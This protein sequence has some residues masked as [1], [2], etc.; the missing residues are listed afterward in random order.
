MS[1]RTLRRFFTSVLPAFA[2]DTLLSVLLVSFITFPYPMMALAEEINAD[3]PLLVED[4]PPPADEPI[5]EVTDEAIPPEEIPVEDVPVDDGTLIDET[6]T[7][8]GTPTDGGDVP[9]AVDPVIDDTPTLPDFSPEQMELLADGKLFASDPSLKNTTTTGL[10]FSFKVADAI[11]DDKTDGAPLAT[12][13]ISKKLFELTTTAGELADFAQTSAGQDILDGDTIIEEDAPTDD[14]PP[15]DEETP[16]DEVPPVDEEA[17]V[18]EETPADEVPPVEEESPIDE[19]PP[20][21]EETPTDEVPPV[22]EETP[23]DT[24]TPLDTETP[25]DETPTDEESPADDT[26]VLDTPVDPVVD[27]DAPLLDDTDTETIVDAVVEATPNNLD[28]GIIMNG[29]DVSSS[30]DVSFTVGSIVANIIPLENAAP[31]AYTFQLVYANPVNGELHTYNQSF[32]LGGIAFNTDKDVYSVG[33]AGT[34]D[35]GV[36]DPAGMPFCFEDGSAYPTL[37]ITTPSGDEETVSVVNTGGCEILDSRRTDPDYVAHYQ[38]TEEG[39]YTMQ[40][41]VDTGAGEVALTRKITVGADTMFTVEREA[42]TRLFPDGESPMKIKITAHED[43][44]GNIMETVPASFEIGKIKVV[45]E[46]QGTVGDTEVIYSGNGVQQIFVHDLNLVAG[47]VLHFGY[48][49]DA[50]DVSP[51]FFVISPLQFIGTYVGTIYEGRAW[52]IVN[53]NPVEVSDAN[54]V[55]W[56][57]ADKDTYTDV[58][59][60]VPATDGTLVYTWKDSAVNAAHVTQSTSGSRPTYRASTA[61][62]AINFHPTLDFDGG[63]VLNNSGSLFPT[64]TNAGTVFLVGKHDSVSSS[65]D[66]ALEISNDVAIFGTLNERPTMYSNTSSQNPTY[67]YPTITANTAMMQTIDW[68]GGTDSTVNLRSNGGLNTVSTTM[69]ITNMAAT[70]INVGGNGDNWLGSLSEL[71]VYKAVLSQSD[72]E[73]IESYLAVKYGITLEQSVTTFAS[74][75]YSTTTTNQTSAGSIGQTFVATANGTVNSISFHVGTSNTAPTATVYLCDA[76]VSELA[77]T[78]IAGNPGVGKTNKVV[79]LPVSPAT[80]TTVT[81]QFD[82]G[83]SV[84]SG[85]EYVFHVK[86]TSGTLYLNVMTAN[87]RYSAGNQYT[88]DTSNTTQD[89]DFV[90]SGYRSGGRD[91][92]ASDGNVVFDASESIDISANTSSAIDAN[93]AST[94]SDD[95]VYN[96]S[97]VAKDNVPLLTNTK[98][99]SASETIPFLTTEIEDAGLLNDKEFMFV[100]STNAAASSIVTTDMPV[101]GIPA[102]TNSRTA[103]EW[104][105]QKNSVVGGSV[106]VDPSMGTFELSFDL[107]AMGISP[108][109][110]SGY[111]LVVDDNGDFTGGTQTVYPA[112]GEPSYDSATNSV[113]FTGVS[114]SDGQYFTL[115]IP[116][117]APGGVT[118]GL[119]AWYKADSGAYADSISTIPAVD[120][121]AVAVWKDQSGNGYNLS[122]QT[123]GP[124]YRVGTSTTAINYSPSVDFEAG[125]ND[126]LATA[127]PGVFGTSGTVV[128]NIESYSVLN[129][130]NM[131]SL[132]NGSSHFGLWGGQ[133]PN[134]IPSL[135]GTTLYHDGGP[136]TVSNLHTTTG[137]VTNQPML[138][139]TQSYSTGT[140]TQAIMQ[141]GKVVAMNAAYTGFTTTNAATNVGSYTTNIQNI[142]GALGDLVFYNTQHTAAEIARINSYLAFKY[143]ITMVGGEH[144]ITHNANITTGNSVG[145][146]FTAKTTASITQF[147]FRTDAATINSASG[148]LYICTGAVVTNPNS[149]NVANCVASPAYQQAISI[150]TTVSTDFTVLLSTAFP[151]VAGTS[152]A[153]IVNGTNIRLRG[154]SADIYPGAGNF[155]F[156]TAGSLSPNDLYFQYTTAA[157][158]YIASNGST[159]IWDKDRAGASTHNLGIAGVGR[160]D[161][162]GL[163]KYKSKSQSVLGSPIVEVTTQN[164]ATVADLEFLTIGGDSGALGAQ[165]T[166]L[167]AGLPA[168]TNQRLIRE[169]QV[170]KVGDVGAVNLSWDLSE[171][172]L[173]AT[174]MS[175]VKLLIDTDTNFA[176]ATISGITPTLSGTTVTFTGVTLAD[177]E[178]FTLAL[179]VASIAPGGVMNGLKL[180]LRADRNVYT[181][182]AATTNATHTTDVAVIKDQSGLGN[183]FSQTTA[184]KRPKLIV[185]PAANYQNTL[186]FCQTTNSNPAFGSNTCTV[187][188]EEDTISDANGVLGTGTY[189]NASRYIFSMVDNVGTDYIYAESTAAAT[190][191]FDLIVDGTNYISDLGDQSTDER[192]AAHTALNTSDHTYYMISEIGSTTDDG[193]GSIGQ[194]VKKDGRAFTNTTDATYQTF[195]GINGLARLSGSQAGG[196]DSN[197]INGRVG[198]V[199]VYAQNSTQTKAETQRIETYMALKYGKTLSNVDT[200]AGIDEGDYVLSDGTT[201]VWAGN[202]TGGTAAADAPWHYGVAGIGRDDASGLYQ[203]IGKSINNDETM[204][205]ALD[206]DFTS[207]NSDASRVGTFTADKQ[208]IMWGHNSMSQLFDTAVS[209]TNTN[210]RMARVWKTKFTGAAFTSK[211]V[212]IQFSNSNVLRLKNG[213]SYVLLESSSSTMSAPTEL[214][215]SA[216][217]ASGTT[218]SVT[219]TGV[220]I[221][222]GKFYSLAT[223]MVAPGGVTTKLINGIRSQ[224]YIDNTWNDSFNSPTNWYA[225]DTIAL[226]NVGSGTSFG[227]PI[228]TTYVDRIRQTVAVGHW[229]DNFAE[230]YNGY[231]VVPTTSAG[232]DYTF[233]ID[234]GGAAGSC[235]DVCALWIDKNGDGLLDDTEKI[236]SV[237][238]ST[239]TSAGQTLTAGN[240]RF[241]FRFKEVTGSANTG[242]SWTKTGTGSFARRDLVNTDYRVEAPLAMWYKGGSG[243]YDDYWTTKADPA[244]NNDKV[245]TWENSALVPNNDLVASNTFVDGTGYNFN[246]ANSA[247][248]LNFNPTLT[249]TSGSPEM[250]VFRDADNGTQDSNDFFGY[251]NGLAYGGGGN[252]NFVVGM[253]TSVS[254]SEMFY[255]YGYDDNAGCAA[256]ACNDTLTFGREDSAGMVEIGQKGNT[257]VRSTAGIIQS[258]VPFSFTGVT[259]PIVTVPDNTTQTVFANGLQRAQNTNAQRLHL[260]VS[261]R[262][263]ELGNYKSIGGHAY[264]GNFAEVI[265][266]PAQLN[267]TERYKVESYLAMKYGLTLAN[268]DANATENGVNPTEGDYISSAGTVVWDGNDTSVATASVIGGGFS[269]A[270]QDTAPQGIAFNPAGTTMMMVGDTNNTVYQ[271]TLGTAFDTSTASYS[272]KSLAVGGQD[273]TP[274]A[275]EFSSDGTKLYVAGATNDTVYQYTL[276]T[277]YD[278]AAATYSG[279]SASVSQDNGAHGIAFNSTGT[280]MLMAGEVNDVV[281]QYTLATPWDISTA[282]YANKSK[283]VSGQTSSLTDVELD[284]TGTKMY[285]TDNSANRFFEYDLPVADDVS[286]AKPLTSFTYTTQNS[287]GRGVTFNT[288]GSKMYMVGVSGTQAVYQYSVSTSVGANAS[289]SNGITVL[290]KDDASG[291]NQIKSKSSELTGVVTLSAPS[292]LDDGDFLAIGNNGQSGASF[293]SSGFWDSLGTVTGYQRLNRAWKTQVTGTPGTVK[294]EVDIED[295]DLNLPNITGSDGK[296]YLLVDAANDGFANDT[297]VQMYDDGTNGDAVANNNIWTRQTVT[298]VDANVFTFAQLTPAAPGGVTNLLSMWYKAGSGVYSNSTATTVAV[299]NGEVKYW[300]D[301]SGNSGNLDETPN[302]SGPTLDADGINFQAALDFTGY[303]DSLGESAFNSF[304]ANGDVSV[305]SVFKQPS[306]SQQQVLAS[307]GGAANTFLDEYAG[308]TNIYGPNF[309][310]TNQ[311]ASAFDFDNNAPHIRTAIVDATGATDSTRG[312]GLQIG[313]P[314]WTGATMARGTCFMFGHEQDSNCGT[315]DDAQDFEGVV[316]EYLVYNQKL[317]GTDL[318][319]VESYLALKYGVS[320]TTLGEQQISNNANMTISADQGQQITAIATGYISDVTFMTGATTANGSTGTLSICSGAVSTATCIASPVYTQTVNTIPTAV[321]T[322]FNIPLNTAFP[323][324][325]AS[326]YTFVLSTT[327]GTNINLRAQNT[328]VYAGGTAIF[329]GASYAGDLYFAYGMTSNDYLASDGIAKMWD[330]TVAGV[331]NQD[332]AGFGKDNTSGLSTTKSKQQSVNGIVSIEATVPADL[333]DLEFA[334]ISNKNSV[335]SLLAGPLQQHQQGTRESV[336]VLD[337]VNGDTKRTVTELLCSISQ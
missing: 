296:L 132:Q 209:T 106:V 275:V 6:G 214:A 54:L 99:H 164:A 182:T 297:P 234:A 5:E 156:N 291:L 119:R 262:L 263:Y 206:N 294:I 326:T 285:I 173:G 200:L 254:G 331:Y 222:D 74:N 322:V 287:S 26:P 229:D 165:S 130:E 185:D 266:Y 76:T 16:T 103:R 75:G 134:F 139:T 312:D 126:I 72:R 309:Y 272:A 31:G 231:I 280:M 78:C 140:P 4:T 111:R 70:G 221:T 89:V 224:L 247:T 50:P 264:N 136:S 304:P 115:A 45:V 113:Y 98:S 37:T 24:E 244:V 100:G 146:V 199:I 3:T 41:V 228:A 193:D 213:Q 191:G 188:N 51:D 10:G 133:G 293:I 122:I 30:F 194:R 286:T 66:A 195:T 216:A 110:V 88:G 82:S 154:N 27:T 121:A 71:V 102:A 93:I 315:F 117:T 35:I 57:R 2:K 108:T 238:G 219:F 313:S 163:L 211:S 332:I 174:D 21:D 7:D 207:A 310:A 187:S 321:S 33:D 265:H 95:Y 65:Y 160:D 318:R 19:V 298:L 11:F 112:S 314:N 333:A 166:E 161:V 337:S 192:N 13:D 143:G 167:A 248:A 220:T 92:I 319:K 159:E 282:T 223:K 118:S 53:D 43:F 176:N 256:S 205:I 83:F 210:T 329:T 227:A 237:V 308:S 49:Y 261:S 202:I 152:Y 307:Y 44:V 328:D 289:Y 67:G 59:A 330:A 215:T 334:T 40:V 18:D 60:S 295:T 242:L 86:P 284:S 292:S 62:E 246:D 127:I 183:D 241:R 208:W 116:R 17:P 257:N 29:T 217:V 180:W 305:L 300:K 12:T 94:S 96:V 240:M 324:T 250:S 157:P 80:N 273:A 189:S 131:T 61:T 277:P 181:D 91:Y 186:Q 104:R 124:D 258:N 145:Q 171:H 175:L 128:S 47:D 302:G 97:A 232:A 52:Q 28:Y 168:L 150:P 23:A 56:L 218:S 316:G 276:P 204:T 15:V 68:T 172:T 259:N 36:I 179:P 336:Q 14:L 178:Y 158:D 249:D 281:Y 84:T 20:T 144:Q 274:L 32:L 196:S 268:A 299:D 301:L 147:A 230:E 198:E 58:G 335:A 79:T 107:D 271:Y 169:W 151:V 235:D 64:A 177:G 236:A 90:V 170:Q 155:A 73:K 303:A 283:S 279:K 203:K 46:G 323:I 101:S 190:N 327:S 69:D 87:D 123:S 39:V 153:V 105:V 8:G 201:V 260:G 85:T 317:S 252:T 212:N 1:S 38:F 138:Y 226:D 253:D 48:E 225:N 311:S 120:A 197:N 142:D 129:Q 125:N 114:L 137:T 184:L 81:V 162:S 148:N 251:T 135:S 270:V 325:A 42:A 306:T 245:N 278:L 288:A 55:L 233:T 9:P 22:D 77:S 25:T 239:V 63:D 255:S 109:N 267:G 269:F 149:T 320:L 243:A 290:A 34:I 141:N